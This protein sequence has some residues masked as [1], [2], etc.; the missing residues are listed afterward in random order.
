[1]TTV[2]DEGVASAG[3]DESLT[4]MFSVR[5]FPVDGRQWSEGEVSVGYCGIEHQ[6]WRE[7][8]PKE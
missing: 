1:M 4:E 7:A 2:R 3:P 8:G 6:I 5:G